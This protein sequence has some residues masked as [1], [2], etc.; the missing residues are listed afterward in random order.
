[1]ENM[2]D[3]EFSLFTITP[4][5][6]LRYELPDNVIDTFI[7]RL[8]AP[9]F[10]SSEDLSEGHRLLIDA[11]QPVLAGAPL[12]CKRLSEIV[13]GI[14]FTAEGLLSSGGFQGSP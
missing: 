8:S 6:K 10:C 4:E 5:D 12:D 9:Q 1:M 7:V 3:V 14:S 13:D 11:L 2:D